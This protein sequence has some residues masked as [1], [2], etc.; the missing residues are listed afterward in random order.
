MKL[1]LECVNVPSSSQNLESL[2]DVLRA[3]YVLL[4]KGCV[5]A[6]SWV[7]N[8]LPWVRQGIDATWCL[9]IHHVACMFLDLNLK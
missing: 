9:G 6:A 3:L 8:A 2:C 7:G 1:E 5:P 4:P